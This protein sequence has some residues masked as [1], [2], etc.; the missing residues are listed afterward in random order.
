MGVDS[1][2]MKG[3]SALESGLR[4]GN[5]EI[6]CTLGLGFGLRSESDEIRCTYDLESLL[7]FCDA[8]VSMRFVCK[9]PSG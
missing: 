7:N 5:G 4:T 2:E 8:A 9:G 3:E 1:G 6:R